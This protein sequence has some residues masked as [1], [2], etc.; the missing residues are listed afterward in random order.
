MEQSKTST[1][2]RKDLLDYSIEVSSSTVPKMELK[3][4]RIFTSCIRRLLTETLQSLN[5]IE[6]SKLEATAAGSTSFILASLQR[7]T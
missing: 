7:S 4:N 5:P 1:G 6:S 2:R 3:V